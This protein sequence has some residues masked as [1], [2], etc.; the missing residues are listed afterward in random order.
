VK[1]PVPNPAQSPSRA[2][3]PRSVTV[4]IGQLVL[5]GFARA[6]RY[7]ISESLQRELGHLLSKDGVPPSWDRTGHVG[8]IK[9]APINIGVGARPA[10]V[11]KHVARAVYNQIT[12]PASRRS[13]PQKKS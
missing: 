5:R 10:I 9:G 6:E 4:N 8:C 1:S 12:R 13:V 11:G 7:E 3:N 2:Q